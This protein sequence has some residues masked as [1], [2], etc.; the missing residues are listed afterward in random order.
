MQSGQLRHRVTIQQQIVGRD[1]YGGE[2]IT[3]ANVAVNIP[4]NVRSLSGLERLQPG[5]DQV[6]GLTIY[7]VLIRY[8]SGL[9]VKMRVM[10]GSRILQIN[11]LL[12]RDNRRRELYLRCVEIFD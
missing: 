7:S 9:D 1:A 11:E 3:W 6:I 12:D 5:A 4:A 8:R 2:V 10:W